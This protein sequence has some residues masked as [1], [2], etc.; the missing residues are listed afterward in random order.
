MAPEG[1]RVG[2]STEGNVLALQEAPNMLAGFGSIGWP[3]AAPLDRCY[4]YS[5]D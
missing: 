1:Q 5:S 3:Q 4:G 2:H